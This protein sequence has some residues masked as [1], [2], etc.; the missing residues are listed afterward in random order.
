M[1]IYK[2]ELKYFIQHRE[3]HHNAI[4]SPIYQISF[5]PHTYLSVG[6]TKNLW[7]IGDFYYIIISQEIVGNLLKNYR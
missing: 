6:F 2:I 3:L 1:R 7:I 4:L 5:N